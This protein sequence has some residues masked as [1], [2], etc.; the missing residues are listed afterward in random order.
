M[1]RLFCAQTGLNIQSFLHIDS[2]PQCCTSKRAPVTVRV[3][4]Q[5]RQTVGQRK[6]KKRFPKDVLSP[7]GH[8]HHSSK[9]PRNVKGSN[10]LRA[11]TLFT[12]SDSKGPWPLRMGTFTGSLNN[13]NCR[14]WQ[15]KRLCCPAMRKMAF[16][17]KVN[18]LAKFCKEMLGYN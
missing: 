13:I 12:F 18:F 11:P 1:W 6:K 3:F 10:H 9:R 15:A 7:C 5:Q 8:F 17:S 16:E 4:I 14:W 2:V